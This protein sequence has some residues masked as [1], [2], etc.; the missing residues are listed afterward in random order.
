MS[1]GQR[2]GKTTGA[3]S[4]PRAGLEGGPHRRWWAGGKAGRWA[5]VELTTP[6]D[7]QRAGL[8]VTLWWSTLLV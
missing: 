2:Y 3:Q 5:E 7:A 8:H 4:R 6:H 1:G